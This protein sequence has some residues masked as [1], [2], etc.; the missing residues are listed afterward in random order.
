MNDN[1]HDVGHSTDLDP[2]AA[3]EWYSYPS[4]PSGLGEMQLE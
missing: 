4:L 2:R 1:V 3:N